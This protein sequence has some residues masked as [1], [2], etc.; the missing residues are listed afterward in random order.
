MAISIGQGD[1]P[2]RELVGHK[3]Q[4][5]RGPAAHELGEK[6]S[7]SLIERPDVSIQARVAGGEEGAHEHDRAEAARARAR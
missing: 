5:S 4:I 1:A 6:E 3:A 7:S 2:A